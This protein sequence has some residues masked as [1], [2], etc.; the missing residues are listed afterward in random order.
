MR[1]CSALFS[2]LLLVAATSSVAA[3]QQT[4][5][6]VV[7][8]IRGDQP[9][10]HDTEFKL[11]SYAYNSN[12]T[13]STSATA[14]M[15][16]G[17]PTFGPLKVSM[18]FPLLAHPLFQ[19]TL[20]LGTR[21]NFVEVRLY[22]SGRLYYKTVFENVFVTSVSTAG[23]DDVLQEV[24]FAYGRV[25]WLGSNDVSGATVP[26]QIGCWDLTLAKAC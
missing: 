20:A 24:E 4:V 17:K 16:A 15:T 22:N 2:S 18:R 23:A 5:Y 6:M 11:N 8:Q 14:G 25:R 19:K 7:D 1:R 26:A 13:V 9:A 3:A 10:P 21:L 12:N